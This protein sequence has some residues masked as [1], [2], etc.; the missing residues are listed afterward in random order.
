MDKDLSLPLL[1]IDGQTRISGQFDIRQLIDAIN[2][3]VEIK[4]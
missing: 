1:I 3:E 4:S 2:A